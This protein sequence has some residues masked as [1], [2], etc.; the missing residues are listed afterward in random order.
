[1][2][3]VSRSYQTSQT[4]KHKAISVRLKKDVL[5]ARVEGRIDIAFTDQQ[6]SAY[7]GLELFGRFL[8]SAGW[9][10]Q[11]RS[12]FADRGFETDYGSFRMSLMTIGMI[13]LEGT[14]LAHLD[15]LRLDPVFHRFC[16]LHRLPS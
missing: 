2:P 11:L 7:A 8:I 3:V 6:L 1:M 15:L 16:R 10:S 9:F 12:V 13:L 5:R 14:R 4:H